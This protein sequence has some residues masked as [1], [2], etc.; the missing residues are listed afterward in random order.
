MSRDRRRGHFPVRAARY[1]TLFGMCYKHAVDEC[2]YGLVAD[3][4][5]E[6]T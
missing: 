2:P 4:E 5:L 3:A 6:R 1:I